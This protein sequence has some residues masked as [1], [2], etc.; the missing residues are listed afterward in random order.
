MAR[1]Y[2]ADGIPK[3]DEFAASDAFDVDARLY[4]EIETLE[5]GSF[6]VSWTNSGIDGYDLQVSIF[7]QSGN[8]IAEPFSLDEDP[9]GFLLEPEISALPDGGFVA[10]W[11]AGGTVR[12]RIFD[13]AGA[14]V[15]PEFQVNSET[16]TG[17]DAYSSVSVHD[18][19][20]FVV[21]W[22]HRD[23]TGND[24]DSFIRAAVFNAD[25]S[26]AIDEFDVAAA[27]GPVHFGLVNQVEFLPNGQFVVAWTNYPGEGIYYHDVFARIYNADGTPATEVFLVN[28]QI[29]ESQHAVDIVVLD[30]ES[31]MITWESMDGTRSSD[32]DIAGRIY[33]FEGH[34]FGD[35]DTDEDHR[36]EIDVAQLLENDEFTNAQN[37]VFSLNGDQS[38]NGAS[39]SYDADTGLV[40]YDPTAADDIQALAQG[41][42]LEDTFTYTLTDA[43]GNTDTATVT[44]TVGGA[45]EAANTAPNAQDDRLTGTRAGFA[46]IEGSGEITISN[47]ETSFLLHDPKVIA[48]KDGGS[49]F[50]WE[51]YDDHLSGIR[52]RIVDADGND[53]RTPFFANSDEYGPQNNF[54]LT[55]LEDGGFAV[56]WLTDGWKRP[57]LDTHTTLR[58]FNADGSPR[59]DEIALVNWEGNDFTTF[60][61]V[62]L[63]NG[64]I[65]VTSFGS[66]YSSGS[67]KGN[68]EIGGTIYSPQGVQVGRPISMGRDDLLAGGYLQDVTVEALENGGFITFWTTRSTEGGQK[69]T[70]VQAGIFDNSGREVVTNLEI[71]SRTIDGNWVDL[72]NVQVSANE[73]GSFVVTWQETSLGLGTEL[74]LVGRVFNP[75][76]TAASEE[77]TFLDHV[78]TGTTGFAANGDVTWLSADQF[79]VTWTGADSS[80]SGVFA[81]VFTADGTPVTDSIVVN[82][83][84]DGFQT[85]SSVALLNDGRF[86][87]NWYTDE[88]DTREVKAQIFELSGEAVD[89]P[90]AMEDSI[91]TLQ[92]SEVL[93]NDTDVDGDAFVFSL[94]GAV[95]ENGASLSY[96]ADSGLIT[97]DPTAADAIQALEANEVMEDTFSYTISD[98]NGGFDQAT[99]T[100][101]VGG[102]DEILS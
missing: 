46:T 82:E 8:R 32:S 75:D 76:G 84:E 59:T 37:L 55:E 81:Q 56:T 51:E 52:V 5:D 17:S 96:D 4:P 98:G 87:V 1:V 85:I 30:N 13:E 3:G 12:A 16:L 25:G 27:D 23:G 93:A 99:V 2:N 35:N 90:F 21:T 47:E 100:V 95:S 34:P 24:G 40:T 102:L 44:L 10:T 36:V 26:V 79:V 7:D 88:N 15:V 50:A 42:S 73:D 38:A 67:Y 49:I 63:S 92:A 6:A 48:R 45:D 77:F 14:E 39:L 64:N 31:F 86:V 83:G 43:A 20:R 22:K 62:G 18:D 97:Y 72:M 66:T 78:V 74:S 54:E 11:T 69:T 41:D 33:D 101:V 57:G 65:L 80:K 70:I 28:E 68:S 58:I 91:A 94:D 9:D 53:V 89:L 29:A 71:A 60:R 61:V 19:G